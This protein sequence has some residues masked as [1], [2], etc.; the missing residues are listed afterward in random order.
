MSSNKWP[1]AQPPALTELVE[2]HLLPRTG[3]VSLS[4][5][6]SE[7][8]QDFDNASVLL[9]GGHLAIRIVRERGQLFVDFGRAH[10]PA[11]WFDSAVVLQLCG[12]SDDAGWHDD[13]PLV[14]MTGLASF[15]RA[16]WADLSARFADPQ[17]S[18]TEAALRAIRAEQ[19]KRRFG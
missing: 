19:D 18:H 9:H 12:Y 14:T 1:P 7:A 3:G 8:S 4:V 13:D 10:G 16:A 11:T 17:Y 2:R 15:L 5:V 6:A